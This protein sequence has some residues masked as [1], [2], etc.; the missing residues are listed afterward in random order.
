MTSTGQISYQGVPEF[1]PDE[2]IHRQLISRMSNRLLIGK[3][4]ITY[5]LTLAANAA[6]TTLNDPRIGIT[7]AICPAM[8][9]TAHA[10]ADLAAGIY[11]DGINSETC[12]IH[13]RNNAATDRVIR[14]VIIG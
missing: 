11:V 3:M 2:K 7:S 13:H 9:M 8:A 4:N 5:D 12:T 14:F 10:A 1:L 6:T